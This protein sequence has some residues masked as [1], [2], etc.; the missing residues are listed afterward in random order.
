MSHD[1]YDKLG[2]HLD[3]HWSTAN[4]RQEWGV[5]PAARERSDENPKKRC[6]LRQMAIYRN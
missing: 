4:Q 2:F 6:A 5:I 3:A 1:T